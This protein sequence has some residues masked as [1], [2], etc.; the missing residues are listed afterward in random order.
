MCRHTQVE[1]FYTLWC[2][3]DEVSTRSTGV[4]PAG[5]RCVVCG[6]MLPTGARAER[7]GGGWGEAWC[8]EACCRRVPEG[9]GAGR[10]WGAR[11]PWVGAPG[12]GRRMDEL[13]LEVKLG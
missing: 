12:A 3:V 5:G 13:V 6:G 1:G 8:A 9:G 4:A 11:E 2:G 10:G 7:P